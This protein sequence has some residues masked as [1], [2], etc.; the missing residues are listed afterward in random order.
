MQN[1][2]LKEGKFSRRKRLKSWQKV[3]NYNPY[4]AYKPGTP[5][6]IK[7]FSEQEIFLAMFNVHIEIKKNILSNFQIKY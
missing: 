5:K 3:G 4:L 2:I 6:S 7:G 1:L